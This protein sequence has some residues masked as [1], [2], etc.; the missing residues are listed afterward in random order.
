MKKLFLLI[1][2]FSL[3]SFGAEAQK[4]EKQKISKADKEFL[5]KQADGIYAKFETS[6]GDIF[7]VLEMKKTPM[8]VGNFI[9]LAEGKI[10]N[11]AKAEGVPYYDGLKFHRVIPSF[12]IQ[13]GCP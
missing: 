5:D 7:C 2:A 1:S 11:T 6:K 3:L 4:K 9:G 10:K 8:T 12:M 13:G